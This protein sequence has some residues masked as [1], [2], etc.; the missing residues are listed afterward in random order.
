[1]ALCIS[2]GSYQLEELVD[3]FSRN[4]GLH[5][6]LLQLN[7]RLVYEQVMTTSFYSHLN[8]II[9]NLSLMSM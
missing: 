1:M 2:Q 8:V 9:V 5:P 3:L 4:D 7:G 6:L